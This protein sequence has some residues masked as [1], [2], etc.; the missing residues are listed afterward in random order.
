MILAEINIQ[1][2][3]LA[4]IAICITLVAI[5]LASF[6]KLRIEVV[7]KSRVNIEGNQLKLQA[8]E[9][10]TLYAERSGLKNLV[11]RL[12]LNGMSAPELHEALI[13]TLKSEYEY[14]QTQQIYVNPDVWN[15]ITRLKDQNVYI[16]NHITANLPPQA[17]GLD[18]GK[19]IIDY[20]ANPNAEMNSIVLDALQFEAKKILS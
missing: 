13:Q 7:Q 11:D 12:V 18:L 4:L 6:R 15:A 14:N 8:L 19:L 17:T 9:R 20:S 10:L 5:L 16:I 1:Y 3:Q 2:I